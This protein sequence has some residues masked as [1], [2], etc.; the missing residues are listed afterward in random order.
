MEDYRKIYCWF[1]V[2]AFLIFFHECRHRSTSPTVPQKNERPLT[3][4]AS[5]GDL[6]HASPSLRIHTLGISLF[7]ETWKWTLEREKY[8]PEYAN[9]WNNTAIGEDGEGE[10]DVILY[11]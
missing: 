10:V 9:L 1:R 4:L 7:A 8:K 11:P 5:P 2:H 6:C 3:L